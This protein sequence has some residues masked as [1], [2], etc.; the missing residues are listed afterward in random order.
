MSPGISVESSTG[1][2]RSGRRG[3]R[4][5]VPDRPVQGSHG[6]GGS[7][8]PGAGTACSLLPQRG[9][10]KWVGARGEIG[11]FFRFE[12]RELIQWPKG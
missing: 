11:S 10:E 12:K 5:G 2:E 4:Y 1:Q 9:T 3:R 8:E 7:R 6:G